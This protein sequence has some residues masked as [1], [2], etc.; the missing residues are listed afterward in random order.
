MVLGIYIY[1]RNR[2]NTKKT[3]LDDLLGFLVDKVNGGAF[4]PVWNYV[5]SSPQIAI[6]FEF[7]NGSGFPNDPIEVSVRGA[8]VGGTYNKT[9]ESNPDMPSLNTIL[10]FDIT[11]RTSAN[12]S[13]LKLNIPRESRQ[14][15]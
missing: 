13:Q 6:S 4:P 5:S 1:T 9:R 2:E 3:S 8:T 10:D 14:A 15:F 7:P 12:T 11:T